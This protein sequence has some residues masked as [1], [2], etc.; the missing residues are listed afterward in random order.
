MS[1]DAV[2]F[3]LGGVLFDWNP[4]YLYRKIFKDENEMEYFLSEVCPMTWNLELDKG[5]TFEQGCIERKALFPQYAEQIDAYNARWPE[6]FGEPFYETHEILKNLA[7]IR[8]LYGL[9]NWPAEKFAWFRKRHDIFNYLQGIVVSG[10]EG[11][12][13]PDPALYDRLI[14]RYGLTAENTVFIDDS[15]INVEGAKNCGWQAIL[16]ENPAALRQRLSELGLSV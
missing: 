16:F 3:D 8:P 15:V 4:R 12:V 5:K 2:V 11:I 7:K 10:E 6:M 14:K 13:K 9:T 1:V